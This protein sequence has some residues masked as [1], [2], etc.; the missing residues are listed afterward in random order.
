MSAAGNIGLLTRHVTCVELSQCY[1]DVESLNFCLWTDG[2]LLT[3]HEAQSACQQRHSFLPRVTN[4]DIQSVLTEFR[5]AAGQW[6]LLKDDDFWLD[7][8][9]VNITSFHWID[10]YSLAG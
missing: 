8:Y 2:S 1:D 10:G 7:I 4:T 9:T 5:A 6:Y 3:K